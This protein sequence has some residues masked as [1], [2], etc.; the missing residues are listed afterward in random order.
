[1]QQEALLTQEKFTRKIKQDNSYPEYIAV[2][3]LAQKGKL[4]MEAYNDFGHETTEFVRIVM[5]TEER[6][7]FQSLLETP[8]YKKL[9]LA[10]YFE[11]CKT[12]SPQVK[13][14]GKFQKNS[15]SINSPHNLEV[16][17]EYHI[18]GSDL[19][20]EEQKRLHAHHLNSLG[21]FFQVQASL[22]HKDVYEN[23]ITEAVKDMEEE[24]SWKVEQLGDMLDDLKYVVPE[25]KKQSLNAKNQARTLLGNLTSLKTQDIRSI[26]ESCVEKILA[27]QQ[28]S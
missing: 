26:I 4:K 7:V 8:E 3:V 14:F 10:F 5:N 15:F 18:P 17:S 11:N 13:A 2:S 24:G 19:S 6:K 21:N 9:A 16:S 25:L 1:M 20:E 23:K 27:E 12:L 22:V 28:K